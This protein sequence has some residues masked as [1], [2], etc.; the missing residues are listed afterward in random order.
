MTK[1]TDNARAN[2][3]LRHG[4]HH[5][6]PGQ[7]CDQADE[8]PALANSTSISRAR[9]T[10]PPPYRHVNIAA[11]DGEDAASAIYRFRA[12]RA[13]GTIIIYPT[14]SDGTEPN[15][16]R[17]EI[18][19]GD[20]PRYSSSS[21]RTDNPVINGVTLSG[22]VI[23]NPVE[24]VARERP[25][26]RF[27]KTGG[28]DATD[29]FASAIVAA[30]VRHWLEQPQHAERLRTA[31]RRHAAARLRSLHRQAIRP[32]QE[33]LAAAA[34]ELATLNIAAARLTTLATAH[35]QTNDSDETR[36]PAGRSWLT[37]YTH[38][39]AHP[40]TNKP[41]DTSTAADFADWHTA[42]HGPDNLAHAWADFMT[43]RA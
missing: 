23:V 41:I 37:A 6:D 18:Q 35:Q 19:L 39:A 17:A 10:L 33:R 12:A 36:D 27:D 13:T 40:P 25:W 22:R 42:G 4:D 28:G 11:H 21:Q 26:L 32:T 15:P 29:G 24:F 31:A 43:D 5:R 9:L 30:I 14:F 7:G 2:H 34:A 38:S 20:G 3:T 8:S 16:T 1:Q